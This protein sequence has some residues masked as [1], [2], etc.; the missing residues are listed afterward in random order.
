MS[1][2]KPLAHGHRDDYYLMANARR[3]LSRCRAYKD[4]PNWVIAMNLFATGSTS[5]NQICR[6]ANIDPDAK[7]VQRLT[8]TKD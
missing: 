6:D 8:T 7:T 3:M 1:T 5:A 2:G 4:Q